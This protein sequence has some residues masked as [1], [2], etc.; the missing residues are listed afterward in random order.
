MAVWLPIFTR[1]A[2]CWLVS[3][4]L[5]CSRTDLNEAG[6]EPR[7]QPHADQ[8]APAVGPQGPQL[9]QRAMARLARHR[10][11]TA[12]LSEKIHLY[13]QEMTASGS[14]VEG[15]PERHW[16]QMDLTVKVGPHDDFAQQRCDGSYL[17]SLRSIDGIPALSR[18]DVERVI[19]ARQENP[20]VFPPTLGLGGLT[21]LLL[22]LDRAFVFDSVR[23]A[24]LPREGGALAVYAVRGHWRPKRLVQ[25]L[26]EQKAAIDDGKPADLS[27]LP[28]MLPDHVFVLLGRDNLFPYRIE[29]RR[30]ARPKRAVAGERC[31][32]SF[33][34]VDVVFNRAV[35][36]RQFKFAEG[37]Y[38]VFDDT[39]G[40]LARQAAGR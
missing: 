35:E 29:Y 15:P 3:G 34:F 37:T 28:E 32:V 6:R 36:E 14:Y 9:I 7:S 40:Y 10:S 2:F 20:Q 22:A 19:Q 18:V 21:D 24:N 8:S 4:V 5:G 39:E 26:P 12:H 33:D 16:L 11:I 25:W 30:E 23:E 27:H 38:P 13:G 31:Y 1:I 17:W